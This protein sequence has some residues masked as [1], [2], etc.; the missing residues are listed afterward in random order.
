MNPSPVGL[1]PSVAWRGVMDSSFSFPAGFV[2]GTATA[3]AQIEGAAALDGRGTSVWDT[4]AGQPGRTK[5]GLGPA[6]ACD[7][8]HRYEQD[9]ALMRALGVKHYRFSLSWSRLF[10]DGDERRNPAGFVF[11]HRLID[12]MLAHGL[13]PWCTFYHWDM[14][15][16]LEARGGWRTR[17]STAAFAA[18]A[19]AAVAAFGGRVKHWFT[20]NE[21]PAFVIHGHKLGLHAPGAM[22]P[23]KVVNQVFHHA[24]LAHGLAVQAVRQHGG[25]G[26]KVG[27]VHNPEITVPFAE[28]PEH[29]AAA[30]TI[31]AQTN[32]H[33]LAPLFNGGGYPASYLERCGADAP[34][35]TP[36]DMTLI[37]QPTD[38]LG[39]N[40]YR[41]HFVRAGADGRPEL[42]PLPEG[43]PRAQAAWL[44]HVPQAMFW[45]LKFCA[46][47]Y[48][49]P[50]FYIAENGVGYHD[51]PGMPAHLESVHGWDEAARD[52]SGEI[53]DL[54]RCQYLRTYLQSLHRAIAAGVPV[55][56]Y[57]LWSFM[58]NFEWADGYV[59]RF[60]LVHLNFTTQ[61][62]TPKLSA[63]WYAEV[64]RRNAV[65]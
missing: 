15:Q 57:F 6:V 24:L 39:L 41:G 42:L 25:P 49:V 36:E 38:F 60:G 62:R 56:G 10:P 4:F 30:R 5:D 55:G 13:T 43:F 19:Q 16:A 26:A 65:I 32:E 18:Y 53:L 12:A 50:E 47:L 31:F 28:T 23:P 22:E 61:R 40:V 63:Q 64:M 14:P 44:H 51:A 3:A 11:Y 35:H 33:L 2:W 37:G 27:L 8:Y 1:G 17:E 9:F 59:S 52:L 45:G 7:H 46:E 34:E 58:D 21:I 54:H 29:I 20:L 48:R